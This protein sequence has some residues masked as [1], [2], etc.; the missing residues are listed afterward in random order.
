MGLIQ[1]T[2]SKIIMVWCQ[3]RAHLK[4]CRSGERV[5]TRGLHI[6]IYQPVFLDAQL[7]LGR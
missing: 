2:N 3:C 6:M 4:G 1:F 7:A 5:L